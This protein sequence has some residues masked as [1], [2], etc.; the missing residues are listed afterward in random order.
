MDAGILLNSINYEAN[1]AH[2]DVLKN[3]L[4]FNLGLRISNDLNDLIIT[5]I[6]PKNHPTKIKKKILTH[7]TP[8]VIYQYDKC[9]ALKHELG[10]FIRD[11]SFEKRNNKALSKGL[12]N[13]ILYNEARLINTDLSILEERQYWMTHQDMELIVEYISLHNEL[14]HCVE[15]SNRTVCK[16]IVIEIPT[17][18]LEKYSEDHITN[19]T[20]S[21]INYL[22]PCHDIKLISINTATKNS[23]TNVKTAHFFIDGK[24]KKTNKYDISEYINYC[25][26]GLYNNTFPMDKQTEL[27][28]A[29]FDNLLENM[30]HEKLN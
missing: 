24:N 2:I 3:T 22:I 7:L 1:Q 21:L 18:F 5:P 16:E 26:L 11:L 28:S 13:I 9:L 30:L 20:Y 27:S 25:N 14:V 29:K 6:F 4:E 15:K 12:K 8:N 19:K 23:D 10:G 17:T